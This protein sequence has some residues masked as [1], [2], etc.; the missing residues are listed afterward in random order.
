MRALL[1]L[2]GASLRRMAREGSVVRALAWPGLLCV[3]TLAAVAAVAQPGP[4]AETV[5][6]QP[7]QAEALAAAGL[8]ARVV[9]DAEAALDAGA[10]RA[11]TSEGLILAPRGWAR[12]SG[13]RAQE[14]LA[15]E[16]VVREVEGRSW[17]LAPPPPVVPAAATEQAQLLGRLLA[18]VCAL[19]AVVLTVASAVRDRESGVLEAIHTAPLPAMAPP[20]ARSLAVVLGCGGA[21]VLSLAALGGL[22]ALPGLGARLPGLLAGVVGGAALGTLALGGTGRAP[23]GPWSGAPA[24]MTPPLR[25]GLVCASAAGALGALWSPA[26]ALPLATLGAAAP[27]SGQGWTALGLAVAG[28]VWSCRRVGAAGW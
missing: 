4:P 11:W 16:A 24:G 3:G 12:L 10:E 13:R 18:M 25:T 6:E 23:V 21:L 15:V 7:V 5:V 20:L 27:G 19:Y 1:L 8:P 9:P 22:L 2:T 14:D 28:L 26:A 17:R